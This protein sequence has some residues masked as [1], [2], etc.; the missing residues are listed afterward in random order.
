M[1]LIRYAGY[2][3]LAPHQRKVPVERA[4]ALRAQGLGWKE[5]AWRLTEEYD[6]DLPFTADGVY[7]AVL[8]AR[9]K[10]KI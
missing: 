9:K 6:R 3:P 7:A 8:R 1:T 10:V 4:A 5:V 2:E